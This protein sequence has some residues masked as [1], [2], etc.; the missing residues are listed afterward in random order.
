MEYDSDISGAREEGDADGDGEQV[1]RW[2][3]RAVLAISG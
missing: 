3:G 1:S 2:A